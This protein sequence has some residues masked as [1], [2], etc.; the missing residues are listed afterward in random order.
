M[1][2]SSKIQHIW[3]FILDG[4]PRRVDFWDSKIS[5]KKNYQLIRKY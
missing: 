2:Y 4:I 5:G 3:T 1:K